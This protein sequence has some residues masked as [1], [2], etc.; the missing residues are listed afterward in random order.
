MG[1]IVVGN[2]IATQGGEMDDDESGRERFF[3]VGEVV[4]LWE[5]AFVRGYRQAP[6][7]PAFVKRVEGNGL[8]SIKMV[9]SNRGKFRVVGWKNLFK[10][11]SFS[12]NVCRTDSVR[13]RAES[14]LKEKANAQAEARFGVELRQT[15]RELAKAEKTQKDIATEGKNIL[16]KQA[17]ESRRTEKEVTARHKRQLEEMRGDVERRQEGA[18]KEQEELY[19]RGRQK[20]REVVRTCE[21]TQI[22]LTDALAKK[23]Q[24]LEKVRRGTA[25]LEAVQKDGMGWQEKYT[26]QQD[27][28][29]ERENLLTFSERSVVEKTRQLTS[30]GKKCDGLEQQLQQQLEEISKH[31]EH[32][33]K[34]CLLF[35]SLLFLS[36]DLP[37][38]LQL[39][40]R[41]KQEERNSK[42]K[43]KRQALHQAAVEARL[44]ADASKASEEVR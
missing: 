5:G 38:S 2:E 33:R 14:R 10:E 6:G 39:Q 22:D 19:R 36:S 15:K 16:K 32:C 23:A 31:A 29:K 42:A 30:L 27:K 8:Y 35:L 26:T 20:T 24:L 17:M 12:K 44:A 37:F 13:V 18:S 4:E 41:A 21:Q 1:E 11:G 43:Y 40:V 7:V 3:T 9:G 28:M 34:V 25:T